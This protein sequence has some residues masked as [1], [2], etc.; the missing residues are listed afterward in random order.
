MAFRVSMKGL[1]LV[2]MA[3]LTLACG[4]PMEGEPLAGGS[5]VPLPSELATASTLP[6]VEQGLTGELESLLEAGNEELD[7]TEGF[8]RAFSFSGKTPTLA[9][10]DAAVLAMQ[11]Y[12]A[13]T[14]VRPVTLT[15]PQARGYFYLEFDP[16]HPRILS[17]YG[18]GTETVQV[19]THYYT[20]LVAAG[21]SGWFR[22]FVVLFPQS[23]K[24]IV[25]EQNG[26]ET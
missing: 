25:F 20:R 1:S 15:Y 19:A 14:S 4:Q 22:L 2:P 7:Y 5:G 24:V 16:L 12:E 9:Q 13:F 18:N 17:T 8:L 6:L 21:A 11:E 23:K 3:L 26:Y 10:A